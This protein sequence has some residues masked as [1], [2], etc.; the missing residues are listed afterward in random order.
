MYKIR[1]NSVIKIISFVFFV[2]F[3]SALVFSDIGLSSLKILSTG[4]DMKES[5]MLHYTKGRLSNSNLARMRNTGW[6]KQMI[7]RINLMNEQFNVKFKYKR[8]TPSLPI[9][10]NDADK[11]QFLSD[12]INV[13]YFESE[14]P[15]ECLPIGRVRLIQNGTVDGSQEC[16]WQTAPGEFLKTRKTKTRSRFSANV[17]FIN[18]SFPHESLPQTVLCPLLVPDGHTF[19]HFMDGVLPKIVQLLHTLVK[20][21]VMYD[22][23]YILY[24]P[25]DPIIYEILQKLGIGHKCMFIAPSADFKLTTQRMVDACVTP[26]VHPELLQRARMM[27]T[28]SFTNL[29]TEVSHQQRYVILLSR[30]FSR[31]AGRRLLN[32]PEIIKYLRDR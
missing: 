15:E 20:H 5:S 23:T 32:E 29:D 26:A 22:M 11:A 30:R 13:E 7:L 2:R 1:I 21:D 10:E 31:N 19:Q 3:L 24:R 16:S 12:T 17:S 28:T 9:F 18:D 8:F 6:T 27:L 4:L 14:R 25:R